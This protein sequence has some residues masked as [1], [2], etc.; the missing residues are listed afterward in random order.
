MRFELALMLADPVEAG[1]AARRIEEQ[2][3][4]GTFSF[5]GPHDPFF[6][7]VLAARETE[8]I[9]LGT[10]VAV[11]FAR[12]PMIVAQIAQDLQRI[13]Q[14]RFYL[15]LGAQIRPHIERRF[16]MPWGKPLARMR[17]FVAAVRAIWHTWNTGEKLDFRGEFYTHTLM[18]PL[19]NPG[20][21]PHGDPKIFLAGVGAKMV[22]VAGEVAD[23]FLVHPLHTRE[24]LLAETLPAL[25][26]GLEKSRRSRDDLEISC[27]TIV[28]LGR[29]DEEVER[30]RGNARAQIAF[31][32]STPAYR[33]VLDH[34]GWG[35][36]QPRLNL[37]SKEGKWLEMMAYVSDEML[38]AIGVSGTPAEA[39]RRLRQR[40]DFASRSSL[41]VYDESGGSAVADLLVAARADS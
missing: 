14:G 4:D 31:Y 32:V 36:L 10:A 25:D 35:D 38:D 5:D 13:S 29:N 28:M 33:G 30:A 34:H 11:A 16:G 27:Q 3:F 21:N 8:R 39:G 9:E 20:P 2:G 19:F 7:L 15:G 37:L 18:T 24:Y 26:R 1:P 23:G 17:E 22:G 40:N 41:I 6:P 12:N